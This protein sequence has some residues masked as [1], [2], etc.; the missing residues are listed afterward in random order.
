MTIGNGIAKD[1][2]GDIIMGHQIFMG[3]YHDVTMLTFNH[4]KPYLQKPLEIFYMLNKQIVAQVEKA[5]YILSIIIETFD[6]SPH[7]N[8]ISTNANRCIGFIKRNTSNCPQELLKLTYH[9]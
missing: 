3:A 7:I 6:W 9:N 8:S 4:E 2:H 5:K 1:V